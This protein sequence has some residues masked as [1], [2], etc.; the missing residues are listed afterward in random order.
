M[1]EQVVV[2]NKYITSRHDFLKSWGGGQLLITEVGRLSQ[3]RYAYQ[4][5][6]YSHS[7]E[8][9][10]AEHFYLAK[11]V[12][13]ANLH[14]LNLCSSLCLAIQKKNVYLHILHLLPLYPRGHVQLS[15][16]VHSPLC[17]Q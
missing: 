16:S 14:L 10:A 9:S 11:A 3:K 6:I 12:I 8:T 4:E 2:L 5:G 15:G 1:S 7:T 17:K 13:M